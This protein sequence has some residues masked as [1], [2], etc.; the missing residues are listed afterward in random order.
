MGRGRLC[1]GGRLA[2][3]AR[4]TLPTAAAAAPALSLPP[5]ASLLPSH[6]HHAGRLA[7]GGRTPPRGVARRCFA[8]RVGRASRRAAGPGRPPGAR[9]PDDRCER[10]GDW[11]GGRRRRDGSPHSHASPLFSR[12]DL[13]KQWATDAA[14]D[15][16]RQEAARGVKAARA[17]ARAVT[18]RAARTARAAGAT[19]GATAAAAAAVERRVRRRKR[20]EREKDGT[21]ALRRPSPPHHPQAA[22]AAQAARW[23]A[24]LANVTDAAA[25]KRRAAL[26]RASRAWFSE[27]DLDARIDAA[28]AAPV[29]L[30]D[31]PP[32]PPPRA[33]PQRREQRPAEGGGVAWRCPCGAANLLA[34]GD[35]VKCGAAKTEG[36]G[37]PRAP[38]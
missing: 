27:A 32:P 24:A 7:R 9:A 3:F 25:A 28:L 37:R 14:A 36:E 8:R 34:R 31:D 13:R 10:R 4:P 38:E 5:R 19:E 23:R 16:A 15:A 6:H 17:A 33:R 11:A 12:L 1:G 22:R 35:C 21:A 26:L 30:F 18:A 20:E 2:V 29:P